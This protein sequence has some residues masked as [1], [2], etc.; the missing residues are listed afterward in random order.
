[1]RIADGTQSCYRVISFDIEVQSLPITNTPIDYILCDTSI[2]GD[3]TNGVVEFDLSSKA[4]EVLGTQ[5]ASD[6][7]VT[8]YYDQVSAD[9]GIVGTNITTP[10]QNTINP[11]PIFARIEHRLYVNC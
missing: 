4:S 11:Q 1:M 2:D 3:D 7:S 6:Y 5:L 8:F 10:I 9:A